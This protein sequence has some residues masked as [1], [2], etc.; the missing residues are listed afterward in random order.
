MIKVNMDKAKEI[1]HEVRRAK[2]TEEFAPLD[3][4]A[5]IPSEAA[6]AEAERQVIRD[7]YNVI[8]NAIDTANDENQLKS[9]LVDNQLI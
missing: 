5:T 8:Q 4:K 2:R 9:V 6:Q 3:I 1:S 7:K